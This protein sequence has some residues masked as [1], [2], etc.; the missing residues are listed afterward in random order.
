[1]WQIGWSMAWSLD[2]VK[3]N[4]L[5]ALALSMCF[6]VD[7]VMAM[8]NDQQP[9]KAL[10][11]LAWWMPDSW[12]SVP[13]NELDRLLFFGL[14]VD[15]SGHVSDRHGWPEQWQE[16]QAA[17]R[18][19]QVPVDVA[20][21]L[22]D[23]KGFNALF[24]SESA[25]N[26]LMTDALELANQSQVA[27]LHLDVEVY[28]GAN[29]MAITHYRNFVVT[30]AGQLQQLS[31]PKILSVFCQAGGHPPLYDAETL[32]HAS[33]VVMQAYDTHYQGSPNAGPVAPLAG[34]DALTWR[35]AASTGVALGVPKDRLVMGFPLYGY[36]WPVKTGQLRSAVQGGGQ[37]TTFA[38][39]PPNVLPAI[40]TSITQRVQQYGATH[41][42]VSGSSHYQ[43]KNTGGRRI[44]GWFE[45]WWS[46]G[47]KFDFLVKEQLGGMAFFVLGYDDGALVRYYL[48]RRGPKNHDA[49]PVTDPPVDAVQPTIQNA[50]PVP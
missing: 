42:P 39:V 3:P 41:D 29:P 14:T 21:T 26:T 10:G 40:Q 12:R 49:L 20:L 31:P 17:T 44:E 28:D 15:P 6:L 4:L 8:G 13:L 7:P 36:E 27:G 38:A 24:G 22:L 5:G 25:V 35:S 48:Q 1:M 30:L 19:H 37:V 9:L 45:D 46:L 33:L 16:L 50:P 32:H 47:K 43:F 18:L 34:S 2:F 11:Y 23:A